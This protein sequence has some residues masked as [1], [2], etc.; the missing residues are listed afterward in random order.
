VSEIRTVAADSLW[1]SGAF[2]TDVVAL[3]FTW[4]PTWHGVYAVLPEIERLLLPL[5]ARPHWGKCFTATRQ[6]LSAAYPRLDDFRDLRDR[7][8]PTRKFD[9]AFLGRVLDGLNPAGQA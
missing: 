2:D 3:H 8:D 4:Q 1:L 9:N 5:G 6:Q 7:T